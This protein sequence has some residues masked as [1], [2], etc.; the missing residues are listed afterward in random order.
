ME[1]KVTLALYRELKRLSPRSTVSLLSLDMPGELRKQG[2]PEIRWRETHFSFLSFWLS[3][4]KTLWRR[5]RWRE[6]CILVSHSPL[7]LLPLF[8]LTGKKTIFV[9]L[10][11]AWQTPLS[12][13]PLLLLRYCAQVVFSNDSEVVKKLRRRNLPVYFAGNVLVDVLTPGDFTFS[14]GG[15]SIFSFFPR[16]LSLGEDLSFLLAVAEEINARYAGY[17]LLVIPKG[18]AVQT[19][20]EEAEKNGWRWRRSLEGEIVEG[21]LCKNRVYMNVTPFYAEALKQGD[22][23]VSFD[24]V[25]IV[26]A[27]GLGKK[28]IPLI[29]SSPR[30]V[31]LLLANPT[32]LFEYNLGL[33]HRF[34]EKGGIQRM[35]V[36]LLWGVVEDQRF[37]L[38]GV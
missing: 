13:F 6:E 5:R 10:V 11:R 30:E 35:V 34:G 32:Y 2:L 15:K 4:F 23:I 21:Y 25:R 38:K 12:L 26:Q 19:V 27:A 1:K 20:Q 36:F 9:H 28:V 7:W 8:L 37:S 22:F 33:S 16:F 3:L 29:S 17:F 18:I 31:A 14:C 24:F